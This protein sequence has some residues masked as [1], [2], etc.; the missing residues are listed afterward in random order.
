MGLP[1]ESLP[2]DPAASVETPMRGCA[3]TTLAAVAALAFL[4]KILLALRTYGTNDV[5]IFEQFSVWSRYLGV[6]LYRVDPTFN[7]PPS[8]IHVLHFFSWLGGSTGLRFPFWLRLP[9]I[10]A[11]AG[12]LWIVWKLLGERT[13]D[14][15][16]FW[17]LILLATA[18]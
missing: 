6:M 2:A 4:V 16:V 17:S 1:I 11:D 13:Q 12:T 8:M 5:Y 3:R 9:G 18:P 10:L 7:H 14:R 15:S